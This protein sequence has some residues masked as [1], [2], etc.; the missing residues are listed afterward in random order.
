MA[1]QYTSK[2]LRLMR[3]NDIIT[4]NKSL[5]K[6][7]RVMSRKDFAKLFNI[8]IT[9]SGKYEDI[10]RSNLRLM[11][12]QQ[13]INMLMRENGMYIQSRD[14]Y[15]EF[16]VADINKTKD[17]VVRF[18]TEVDVY[19]SCTTRLEAKLKD[20]RQKKTWGT[21]NK[22]PTNV[23]EGLTSYG[24]TRRHLLLKKRVTHY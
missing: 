11:G 8:P 15:S 16:K 9:T 3:Y 12:A 22:V 10:H 17:T 5:F 4:L 14:Y 13:E 23:V 1:K 6:A 7:G 21:Y 18:S 19:S 24:P 2:Q 20:R